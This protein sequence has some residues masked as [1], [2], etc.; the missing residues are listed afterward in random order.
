MSE[1]P[2]VSL[3]MGVHNGATHLAE[4]VDSV[5]AQSLSDLEL[6]VVDDASTDATPAILAGYDDARLVVLRNH[7]NIGLT[8]SLNRAF[9]TARGPYVGRQDAD[10]R[11]LSDRIRRQVGLLEERPEVSLC[12]TWARFIDEAGRVA[13]AGHPPT[14][15]GELAAGLLVENKIFHGTILMRRALMESVGG[16]REAFRYSQ[17][18]DLYLRALGGH[19]LANVPEELYELRFHTASISDMQAELQHR[20]RTLARELH[21]QREERGSD[22]L[23]DGVPVEVLLERAEVSPDY[24]RQRAMYRRLAG[25]LPGYRTALREALRRNPRDARA[26]AHLLISAFGSRG[27]AVADRAWRRMSRSRGAGGE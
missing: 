3:M 1:R 13:G 4:A 27:P 25:D 18:Y 2:L 22:D 5:L 17:D 14:D 20:Y 21:A 12:G 11:S 8:R 10:D 16:Y 23:D 15:S 7:E 9:A 19:R 6:I 24:W 26:Y